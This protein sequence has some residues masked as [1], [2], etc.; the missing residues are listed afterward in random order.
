[1]DG[2]EVRLT[3]D[4]SITEIFCA[5]EMS[6]QVMERV[7]EAVEIGLR[8]GSTDIRVV[9]HDIAIP[10]GGVIKLDVSNVTDGDGSRHFAPAYYLG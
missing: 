6:Q 3:H 8:R 2:F 1:M 7:K 10:E 4:G 5:G 9:A